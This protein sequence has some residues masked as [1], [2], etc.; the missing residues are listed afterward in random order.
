MM[1]LIPATTLPRRLQQANALMSLSRSSVG[2]V[3]PA[4]GGAI[5]ALANPGIALIA[6]A[7]TFGISALA[8]SLLRLDRRP[9]VGTRQSFLE[10]L[11]EGLAVVR[12]KTWLWTIIVYFGFF[13]L[14]AWP[15]LFVLGPF[16]AKRALGGVTA[17]A[18]I[19]TAGSIGSVVGGL[20]TLR[21]RAKRPLLVGELA[22]L[23]AA[24]PLALIALHAPVPVI[25]M[26]MLVMSAGLTFS[27]ALFHTT[28][29]QQVPER[30]ISRVSAIDW[31]ST[32]ALSPVGF[33]LIGLVAG[34]VGVR[35]TMFAAAALTAAS[36]LTL[37][38][39]PSVRNVRAADATGD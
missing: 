37:I 18:V 11:K 33:A 39:V 16:E 35:Q 13:N 4:V 28:M 19:L 20:L 30:A 17:W 25:A 1:G 6:D 2:I 32:L 21:V 3:G 26:A 23:P 27:D 22:C 14:T 9:S 38:A 12:S 29:Q 5:V 10:E 15:A 34:A 7:A 8:L 36:V 24:L 31:T